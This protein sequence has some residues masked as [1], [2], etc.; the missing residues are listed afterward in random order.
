MKNM[1]FATIALLAALIISGC[2]QDPTI[3]VNVNVYDSQGQP[4]DGAY[5]SAY[6]NYDLGSGVE[7]WTKVNGSI[8]ATGTTKN[9]SVTL[10]V[11]PGNYA[12]KASLGEQSGGEEKLIIAQNNASISIY[13][14][15]PRQSATL[16]IRVND[17]Q[18]NLFDKT[19]LLV[20]A[21]ACNP[22][23]ECQ[24]QQTGQNMESNPLII[25]TGNTT[26]TV[27]AI[28][29]FTFHS[30]GYNDSSLSITLQPGDNS[31][32][33]TMK[34]NQKPVDSVEVSGVEIGNSANIKSK[35]RQNNGGLLF[36]ADNGAERAVPFYYKL[37]DSSTGNTFD[38][39]GKQVWYIME[40]STAGGNSGKT[41]G[42]DYEVRLKDG[43]YVNGRQWKN[44]K[45]VSE[46][47]IQLEIEKQGTV[48]ANLSDGKIELVQGN[49][50][51]YGY[52]KILNIDS[53]DFEVVN[54]TAQSELIIRADAA[55]QYR[56]A[57]GTGTLIYNTKGD[58]TDATYGLMLLT[59][60]GMVDPYINES[61]GNEP[62]G[63]YTQD[64]V[65]KVKYA[66]KYGN[67]TEKLFLLLYNQELQAQN[68]VKIDFTGTGIKKGGVGNLA[69]AGGYDFYGPKDTDFD[70][71]PLNTDIRDPNFNYSAEFKITDSGLNSKKVL[72]NTE[73]GQVVRVD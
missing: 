28:Y 64:S 21:Q 47:V 19:K 53:T 3:S 6:S 58:S 51:R 72:V 55:I 13:M 62:L 30:D 24:T 26:L 54:L 41:V 44:F 12:F 57:N 73:N 1:L 40:F 59:N 11:I 42:S 61:T 2:S 27:G 36:R 8:Q 68:N 14:S 29:N 63:L 71:D 9:G 52:D 22:A 33:V 31:F 48:N 34:K 45:R 15:K 38:F 49:G 23:G 7:K 60:N 4:V 43:D 70:G 65:R 46:N 67:R 66:V 10:Q 56:L 32:T 50:T 18:G 5:V 37:N 17:E 20:D 25:S 16:T 39:E 69:D 35:T